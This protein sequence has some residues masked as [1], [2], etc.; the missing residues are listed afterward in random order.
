MANQASAFPPLL[1]SSTDLTRAGVELDPTVLHD[2]ARRMWSDLSSGI[3]FGKKCVLYPH[4]DDLWSLGEFSFLRD[5]FKTER[6]G[7]K[8]SALSSVGR[9][10]AAVKIVGANAANRH[11]GFQRSAST[12]LL[13]DKISMA[14][15]CIME[16]TGI[17]AARTGTYASL[18]AEALFP[19]PDRIRVF[20]FGGG[21]IAR[22]V[23]LALQAVRGGSIDALWIKTRS[24]RTAEALARSL[25]HTTLP[26]IP[27]VD[28]MALRDADLVITASNANLP[29]FACDEIKPNAVV[30]HLGGD[31]TPAEYLAKVLRQG[32]LI[33]DDIA[34]VSA[35]NSQSLALY[36][37]RRGASLEMQG[38]LL[39]IK[40][41][42]DVLAQEVSYD[43]PVHVTC[44]GLPSLDLYIAE[45]AYRSFL[46]AGAQPINV[47][48]QIDRT[49]NG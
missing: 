13:M 21:P 44:V 14:P 9:D 6:L 32:I 45:H 41:L 37:S 40:N 16:G 25:S 10:Y 24:Q 11:F 31:E 28:T 42:A 48:P 46:S 20:I 27:V 8:L 12:I 1:I 17:S 22:C 23:A 43:G 34:M 49:A 3:T 39:G 7:W 47:S 5:Q 35:R 38:P 18:I 26:V 4:E 30:L 33:C 29:V 2:L 19:G 36:F 15:L